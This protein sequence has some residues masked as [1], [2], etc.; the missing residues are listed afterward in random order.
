[1]G[2]VEAESLAATLALMWAVS[3]GEREVM[4]RAFATVRGECSMFCCA[5]G[6]SQWLGTW[7]LQDGGI[8]Q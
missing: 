7:L 4:L 6:G 1:M 8:S 5:G 3:D 2:N